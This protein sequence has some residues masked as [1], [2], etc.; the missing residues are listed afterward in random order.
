MVKTQLK[1]K[2]RKILSK[3][4][5]E[6]GLLLYLK[7]NSGRG[8]SGRITV[9]HR[10]G[11]VKRLYRIVDFGQEKLDIKGKV[12]A[13]EYDPN[14]TAFLALIEYQD[15]TKRYVLAPFKLKVEDEVICSEKAEIKI[16]NRARLENI[17]VGTEVHNIELE[18]GRGGKVV[19]SAGTSAKIL[20]HEGKY[21]HLNMPSG[22]VRK[23]FKE[24]FA[25]VGQV[26]HPEKRFEK[27]GKAGTKRLRG[28]RPTVRGTV[29]NPPDHPHGGG[30]GKSPI[31]MKHPKT[32]WGK[33]AFGVR[34]RRKKWT[35]KLIIKRRKK[36]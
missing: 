19:R 20:A 25:S 28:W 23:V 6:K 2:S 3:K 34:T 10:G 8:S 32:P 7:K 27:I 13:L 24:C 21:A 33:I 12:I 1:R 11:G 36:K 5:P 4:K 29:M 18:Q 26:S 22:E 14:R 17:P 30:T 9:R 35:D 15:G 31:G 16:G